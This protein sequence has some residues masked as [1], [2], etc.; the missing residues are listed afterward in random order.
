MKPGPRSTS[1][2]Q[3]PSKGAKACLHHAAHVG[4]AA[5][6][7]GPVLVRDLGDDG[8]GRED[9]LRDR[10]G[11]LQR[12]ARDHRRVDDALGDEVDDLTG[13]RVQALTLLGL[14][15]VVDDDRALEAG[16]LRDLAEG[17]L[18]RA[19][20]D[21]GAGALVVVGDAVDVDRG[22]GAQERDAA[23]GH[24]ALLER[25][26]GRLEGVLD[27][28]LLLLHLRLGGRADLHDGDA[29]GELGEA[30]LELLAIEVGVGV[31]DL[32]LDLVD[33]A[34]DGVRVTGAVDDRRRVL[35]DHDATGAAELR[36]LRVLELEAHLLGD[37]LAAGEDRDVLE[38]A[39][40][41]VAEARRLDGDAGERA[42]QLVDDERREGLALD[43][44]G[45]D[46]QRLARLDRLLEHGQDVPDR[47][48]LLVGD[49][50][51]RILEDR[52]HPLLVG[53]HVRRDVAL[54]ELH[55]LGEL[56]VHAERL[57]LLDVHDAVLAD[58]LDGVGDDVA[59]LV[60]A[61]GDGR[62]AGDLVLAGDLLGL[63][64]D[65][66]DDGVDGLLDAALEAE[67]VGAGRD[68]LEAL[69]DDRLGEDGCGR[70]AV[71]GDVVGR[72]GDLADELRALVLE[73]VLDLDLT[74][75]GDAVV[76]DRRG[77]ELLVEHHV[78][79]LR[80][81]RDL[82]RVRHGV[83]AGLEGGASGGVVLQFLVSHV[84]LSLLTTRSWR[85]R[86][87]RGAPAAP[88]PRP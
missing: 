29:A 43:V 4:H 21:A 11:V 51:V 56:E 74:S 40:A 78:A 27:A 30:L 24:D 3:A 37:D 48:D 81:E 16:V 86:R 17:L 66:V 6:D 54:V 18:E 35:R 23:A 42:A 36:E 20:D 47:A 75:D 1:Q 10:G 13:R 73:D 41:A 22:R 80:A 65:L 45:D 5:A 72:R 64:L 59:D 58:L 55:A 32:R 52:L 84:C 50:D 87:S 38:H 8:L 49:E 25:R 85:E 62:H 7:A 44:L 28:V 15:D 12:R 31:F 68:V 19:Q 69:A 70:R 57:A 33:A 82:H 14:P 83:D 60:V 79:A 88:R 53:D 39:L 46:Q 9:V 63:L 2:A 76:R 61:G 77:A 34:L 26:A 67:R 71:A